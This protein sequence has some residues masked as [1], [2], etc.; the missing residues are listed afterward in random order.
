MPRATAHREIERATI[1]QKLRR[2]RRPRSCGLASQTARERSSIGAVNLTSTQREALRREKA[3]AKRA[4]REARRERRA[5][6]RTGEVMS[7]GTEIAPA[8]PRTPSRKVR[9]RDERVRGVVRKIRKHASWLDAPH[10][11]SL[12]YVYGAFFVKIDTPFTSLLNAR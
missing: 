9:K 3:A 6:G 7:A 2:C 10:F 5:T 1:V 8:K 4:K 12:L 11:A